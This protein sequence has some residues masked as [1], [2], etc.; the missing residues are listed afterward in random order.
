MQRKMRD[1]PWGFFCRQTRNIVMFLLAQLT[2]AIDEVVEMSM[3][4]VV[5]S[6]RRNIFIRNVGCV[7]ILELG[8]YKMHWSCELTEK[9]PLIASAESRLLSKYEETF[10]Q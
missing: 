7:V 10:V 5:E 6:W 3:A 9:L 2:G 4:Q 8:E 1:W